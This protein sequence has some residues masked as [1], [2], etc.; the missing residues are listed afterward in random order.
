MSK[1]KNKDIFLDITDDMLHPVNVLF[2]G[3]GIGK[4]FS[5]LKYR[6]IDAYNDESDRSKFIWLRD[7]EVVIKKIAAG[8]S[9]TKPIEKINHDFP[10]VEIRKLEGNY[11]FCTVDDTGAI[12]RVLGYLMALSTFHNARGINYDDVKCIVWDEF[13]PEN[14]AVIK[15]AS[16]QGSIYENMYESVNR[17]REIATEEHEA[18]APVTMIFLSNTND[19]FSDVLQA[20][21]LDKII[22][23]MHFNDLKQY[24]DDDVWIEFFSNK[25]FYD[26]K[27]DTLLYRLNNNPKFANMA[28]N[29]SFNNS[30]ALIK[31]DLK[32]NGSIGLI[33]LDS[34]Y[35]L[36][37]LKD[38]SLYWKVG[39]HKKLQNYD[40]NNDQEALL[41]RYLF[42]DKLRVQYIAG[43]MF[44]DSIYTQKN[45]LDYARM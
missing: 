40:M 32:L 2:G 6:V 13:I 20:L 37:Q 28:L 27:K 15:N 24:I 31:P 39:N 5:V 34:K 8:N 42:T 36:L 1:V 17:N 19:I 11:V 26:A 22:E 3:R 38:G 18:E 16:L 33:N 35:V 12:D 44:F 29:N 7:S 10:H 14:G 21:G 4:T 23:H 43:N 25:A 9:L 41:F 45:I 30:M